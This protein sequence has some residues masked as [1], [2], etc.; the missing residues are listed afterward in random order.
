M[1]RGARESVGWEG[2]VFEQVG[3]ARAVRPRWLQSRVIAASAAA[4][5]VAGAAIAAVPPKPPPLPRPAEAAAYLVLREPDPARQRPA[6]SRAGPGARGAAAASAEP[7]AI[8]HVVVVPTVLPPTPAEAPPPL[9]PVPA[10]RTPPVADVHGLV[11]AAAALAADGR[12]SPGASDLLRTPAADGGPV[13]VAAEMLAELPRMMNQREIAGM[14]GRLYPVPLRRTGVK[15]EVAISFVIGLD[16]RVEMRT[17]HVVRAAHPGLIGPTLSAVERMRFRPA[18]I[19]GH[20]VRVQAYL[21][22]VWMLR[23]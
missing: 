15:G 14:L 10:A 19:D 11:L 6:T 8:P 7:D 5:V 3:C 1:R 9:A 17:I 20:P 13:I 16:G 18:S 22:V 4:H 2:P 23:N 12:G 21:P